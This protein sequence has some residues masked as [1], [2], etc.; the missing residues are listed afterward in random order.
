M[1][2]P[3]DHA[4][5]RPMGQ[6][7]HYAVLGVDRG[8]T[9]DEI[10][11]AFRRLAA[12]LH[13]DRNPNDASAGER[14]KELNSAYQVLSDPQRRQMY[15]RFG[16]RAEDAGSPF[17]GSG[18]FPGGVVDLGDI[19][20]D[21]FLGDLLGAF[22]VGRGDRGDIKQELEIAFEEAAFGCEKELTYDRLVSCTDCSGT[23]AA[24]GTRPS[25]CSACSGRGRVRFQQGLFPIAVE[26]TC[27]R[28]QGSGRVVADPCKPCR[29]NGVKAQKHTVII[30]IPPGVDAGTTRVVG[31]AGNRVRADR[32]AGDLEIM[33]KVNPHP[34]FRRVD[35]DVFITHEVTFAQASL[36]AEVE[37]QTLDGKGKLRIPQGTQP[38]SVLRIRGK[39]VPHRT[40]LGRGDQRVQ[41][42][43]EVPT[44]LTPRQRELLE[45]FAKERGESMDALNKGR[46]FVDKIKDLF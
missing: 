18:P 11:Q 43:L 34:I 19:A 46:S 25:T 8:A 33:L 15:D 42:L 17:G 21:G 6:R 40:G 24:P 14:F 29:G 2:P 28:C 44:N 31:G 9:P 23:G 4:T 39:G 30:T 13:P 36:G 45:E 27:S 7:D 20:F 41:I 16:H 26:R 1:P 12:Q 37:V 10:K 3:F 22:G 38:G 5:Q 35:D 32:P